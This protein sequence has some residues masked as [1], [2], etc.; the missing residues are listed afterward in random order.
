MGV[1]AVGL[2]EPEKA[3]RFSELVGFP[4]DQLYAGEEQLEARPAELVHAAPCSAHNTPVK[5][6]A[7]TLAL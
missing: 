6:A 3:R 5:A 1:L 4:L 7:G 2:G